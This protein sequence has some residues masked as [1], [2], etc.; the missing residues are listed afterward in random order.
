[1]ID[2]NTFNKLNIPDSSGVYFF[3]EGDSI[4]YIGRA[5]S[6]FN[7]VKSYFKDNLIET[8]G[9]IFKDLLFRTNSLTWQTTDSVLEAIILESILIKKYKPE[10]NT[11]D[12]DDRSFSYIII[13][14]EEYPRVILERGKNL[15]KNEILSYKI[16]EKFG[17]YPNSGLMRDALKIIRKIFPFRDRDSIKK[18]HE[19]FYSSI[20]LSPDVS[21]YGSEKEYKNNI[22]NIILFLSGKKSI[23][24]SNLER[25]LKLKIKKQ[26]FEEAGKISY[27]IKAL[28]HI[29]DVALIK[30]DDYLISYSNHQIS[31]IN[32]SASKKDEYVIEAYDISHFSGTEAVGAMVTLVNGVPNKS[33]YRLFK[34]RNRQ[35]NN[36][37]TN[38]REILTRRI[39]HSEWGVPNL[40]V[41]DGPNINLA[42]EVFEEKKEWHDV[43]ITAVIKD[44]K[45]KPKRIELDPK[46]FSSTEKNK[47]EILFANSEA[48]RFALSFQKKRRKVII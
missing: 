24:I 12:K 46:N 26:E 13:T 15:A 34:I 1:M 10:Y 23:L 29:E 4:L 30:R 16:K 39:T 27:Q 45:H 17:P 9:E 32:N 40:V 28:K 5:T 21:K 31:N 47:N 43:I 22:K 6:L 19:R 38:L 36:E 14:D 2:I 44:T 3:K 18:H 8:R 7:R 33:K 20:G 35:G 48:H 41:I 42:R 25:D 11:K 37:Y